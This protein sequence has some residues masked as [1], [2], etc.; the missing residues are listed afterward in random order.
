MTTASIILGILGLAGIGY[1]AW[2]LSVKQEIQADNTQELREENAQLKAEL[3][4]RTEEIGRMTVKIDAERSEKDKWA[5]TNKQMFLEAT[6][7]EAKIEALT[8]ERDSLKKQVVKFETDKEQHERDFSEKMTRLEGIKLSLDQERQRVIREDEE[9]RAQE[10]LE[11]DRLWADHENGVIATLT[12]LCKQPQFAFTSYSNTNLPEGFDGS[13]KPDFMIEFLD[14]Y[15]VFDAKVSKAK[16]LQT[17]V[18]DQVKKT[19]EKVKNNERIYKWIFLVVPATA[20]SEL[21]VHHYPVE[22]YQLF[23][24]SPEAIPAV[25]ASLKNITRY[26]FAEQMDPQQRENIIQT[27]AELDFHVNLRNAVDIVMSKMGVDLLRKTQRIDPAIADEVALKKIPM[28]AKAS[29]AATEIK[30]I[31]SDFTAQNVEAQRLV[32][33]DAPVKKQSLNDAETLLTDTLFS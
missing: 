2:K 1:I 13:L 7:L 31:V 11:R 19:V 12:D 8:M 6:K 17:Y 30:K 20:L 33:P 32:S 22:G 5:G 3:N 29:V 15:V 23:V 14:Q 9:R 28:N 24:I 18:N 4:Q 25:L 10:L 26:E 27:I 16:S 21:K